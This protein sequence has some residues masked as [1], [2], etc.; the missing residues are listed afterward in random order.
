M[1]FGLGLITMLTIAGCLDAG[2]PGDEAQV[3]TID[4]GLQSCYST[5]D[6]PT[7]NGV[8]VGCTSA[9]FCISAP[10]AAYCQQ[11]DGSYYTAACTAAPTGP[12]CGDG[13]CNG[14]ETY[15]SCPG[16]CPP[17]GPVCGDGICA[18]SEHG[19]CQADCW[20]WCPTCNEP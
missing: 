7:Y 2:P 14:G 17:P 8:A 18:P 3:S 19:S 10:E 4:Q 16:D 11:P 9:T 6:R 5:C 12:Y 1:K 15:S 20:W 13:S